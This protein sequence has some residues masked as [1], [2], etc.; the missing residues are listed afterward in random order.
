MGHGVVTFSG[1]LANTGVVRIEFR[2]TPSLSN[3]VLAATN[4][5]LL[6]GSAGNY[7]HHLVYYKVA[8]PF[9][10]GGNGICGSDC[11]TVNAINV[12]PSFSLTNKHALLVSAGRKLNIT[13]VRPSPTYSAANPAQV[14]PSN[15]LENYF[16]SANNVSGGLVFD[17]TNL[18][19]EKFNDQVLIVE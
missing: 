10:P 6:G 13:N 11:L 12:S 1:I 8:S 15:V 14:R 7:W 18:P 9:L 16:D 2:R 19:L 5:Y 17:S 4:H 3:W